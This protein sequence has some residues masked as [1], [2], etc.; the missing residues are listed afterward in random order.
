MYIEASKTSNKQRWLIDRSI[1]NESVTYNP[2]QQVFTNINVCEWLDFFMYWFA[3]WI[4]RKPNG[5]YRN[6]IVN[7]LGITLSIIFLLVWII[8]TYMDYIFSTLPT[9]IDKNTE[10]RQLLFV[11]ITCILIFFA[12][13]ARLLSMYYLAFKFNFPWYNIINIVEDDATLIDSVNKCVLGKKKS[14]NR[15]LIIYIIISYILFFCYMGMWICSGWDNDYYDKI[16]FYGHK[17]SHSS[18]KLIQLAVDMTVSYLGF[19]FPMIVFQPICSV[20]LFRYQIK[21][22]SLRHLLSQNN[23]QNGVPDFAMIRMKYKKYYKQFITSKYFFNYYNTAYFCFYAAHLWVY[24]DIF[25]DP[26]HM[27]F[28]SYTGLKFKTD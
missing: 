9:I 4:F 14:F 6:R 20:I 17:F 16:P 12:V 24:I 15:R 27:K 11:T 8:Y 19:H 10:T 1:N 5:E 13:C 22:Y 28:T 2:Q 7:C 21:L 25:L 3:M 23:Q 26:S 18:I